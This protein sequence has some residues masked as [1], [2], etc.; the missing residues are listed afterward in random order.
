MP[1]KL[2]KFI[3]VFIYL[4]FF[5]FVLAQTT[6]GDVNN[7]SGGNVLE[8][9]FKTPGEFIYNI[10]IFSL[11]IGGA[12]AFGAIVYGGIL[13]I[14]GA[15]NPSKISEANEWIKSALIG[16]ILLLGVYFVLT[17]INPNL[18][19]L[20]L[21]QL[22]GIK[23]EGGGAT[24]SG[25]RIAG[26]SDSEARTLLKNAGID[27]KI[28]NT[29]LEGIKRETINELIRMKQ[30]CD[31]WMKRYYPNENNGQCNVFITGGTEHGPHRSGYCSHANG[32]KADI[33]LSTRLNEFIEKTY[34]E[35]RGN[36]CVPYDIRSGDGALMYRSP[37][38]AI[39]AR[40]GDHWDM[41][42][43]FACR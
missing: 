43:N 35:K 14:A 25:A 23:T 29:T 39:Y 22:R 13:R 41:Q 17:L 34:C 28:T 15:G 20:D 9:Q 18:V 11:S 7:V 27:A 10:Y 3:F 37:T 1:H 30:E 36:S 4:L 2:L 5:S 24:D 12:L 8:L 32:Y 38:G 31:A 6:A 33:R 19:K 16:L 40:E 21:P 26:L 42:A